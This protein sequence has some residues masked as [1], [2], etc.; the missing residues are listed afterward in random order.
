[1]KNVIFKKFIAMFVAVL[2]VF[3]M[4]YGFMN[5]V[6]AT[7]ELPWHEKEQF[8]FNSADIQKWAAEVGAKRVQATDVYN[9]LW[10]AIPTKITDDMVAKKDAV[11]LY[12]WANNEIEGE[13]SEKQK[14][15]LNANDA[16]I[17][18][19]Y[20]FAKFEDKLQIKENLADR[21]SIEESDI[22]ENVKVVLP[23]VSD[24][25]LESKTF[26]YT[27]KNG[28]VQLSQAEVD[29]I[30]DQIREYTE[31]LANAEL[32]NRLPE[33]DEGE[34]RSFTSPAL[35]SVTAVI[36]GDS[37]YKGS[38]Y[39]LCIGESG[40]YVNIWC[41]I[42]TKEPEV[43]DPEFK[44][45]LEYTAIIDGKVL[46][47]KAANGTYY[48]PYDK[49][50]VEKDADVT[51][52][53][54]SKTGNDIVLVDGIEPGKDK[55]NPNKDGWYYVDENDKKVIAKVYP[56]DDYDNLEYNGIVPSKEV[57]LTTTDEKDGVALTDKQTISIEWPFRIIAKTQDPET[58]TNDTK[59]VRV[60]ITTNL[61]IE[62][63]KLPDGWKFTSDDEGK[64][65]HRVYREFEKG[66][67]YDKDVVLTRNNGTDTDD[68]QVKVKW[69]NTQ[70][71]KPHAQSGE[72]MAMI[73]SGAVVL[74]AVA[75]VSYKKYRK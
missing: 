4:F 40:E 11:V 9:S 3:T 55:D 15:R 56:F 28:K 2:M 63:E 51:A 43:K 67:D 48:P 29:E 61:P 52:T 60:E 33:N 72:T 59:K 32:W 50:N 1:M 5:H 25:N 6:E 68:R 31:V 44:T 65:Q 54:R 73:I 47:T 10:P 70:A 74:L 12:S 38:E 45:S 62:E 34:R 57:T 17:I 36:G 35:V 7:V 53:I 21:L 37:E 75:V 41:L 18:E 19:R 16:S 30:Y 22:T 46:E 71:N 58:V 49:N 42:R 39:R 64:T 69:D 8:A 23:K 26:N 66:E 24:L 20:T 13:G 14:N 27:V